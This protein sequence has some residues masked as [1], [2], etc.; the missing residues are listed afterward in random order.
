MVQIF[1]DDCGDDLLLGEAVV[2]IVDHQTD[3]EIWIDLQQTGAAVR[4]LQE[5]IAAEKDQLLGRSLSSDALSVVAAP[6]FEDSCGQVGLALSWN[7]PEEDDKASY[8][9]ALE[10]LHCYKKELADF[11][12]AKKRRI[13]DT[14]MEEMDDIL[15]PEESPQCILVHVFTAQNVPS[16]DSNGS[17]DPFV[18]ASIGGTARRTSAKPQTLFPS[19]YAS[20]IP[21][22]QLHC[23]SLLHIFC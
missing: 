3:G 17:C 5:R 11:N 21:V 18:K 14:E 2:P 23:T 1:E 12:H 20:A 22:L 16:G 13:R 9:R 7:H 6:P 10:E 4:F 15:R 19:W 8:A